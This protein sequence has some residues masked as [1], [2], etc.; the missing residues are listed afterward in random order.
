MKGQEKTIERR[1]RA[2]GLILIVVIVVPLCLLPGGRPAAAQLQS[3][4]WSQPINLSNSP[5][6]SSRPAI[7][8]DGY[9]YVHV[10]WGE[11]VGGE[12][13]LDEP[14]ALIHNG[15]T[16]YYTQWDGVSWTQ[17]IDILF[18]PDD[19]VADYI[20][21]TV[22]AE[23][24]LHVVWTGQSN[25]YYSTAPAWQADS[26]HGWSDP[27]VVATDSARS[28]WESD[29]V[30]DA[31]GNIHIVY[32]TRGDEPGVYHIQSQDGGMT[33]GP[34][35]KLS[36]PLDRLEVSFSN[37]RANADDAGRVHVVWQTNQAE[38]YGQGVYYARSIDGGNN[39]MAPVRM[40]YRDEGEYGVSFPYLTSI[41]ESELHLI[42]I[43]GPWHIG[44]YHR[45]SR[46]G[47]ETWSE[48]S[49]IL[50]D[51]EGINGYP[52]LLVDGAGGLHLVITMRTVT[53]I[54][55]T[56]YARWLGTDWSSP[57]LIVPDSVET[58]PGAHWTAATVRLGNEIHVVWNTNFTIRAGE[59]W[60]TR[61]LIAGVAQTSAIP[62]PVTE[63]AISTPAP[64]A[65]SATPA[66]TTVPATSTP[67]TAPTSS[68]ATAIPEGR[69]VDM[70]L[71]SLAAASPAS[72]LLAGIV[73]SLLLVAG[74]VAWVRVRSR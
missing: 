6:S 63:T 33:W 4:V 9:G 7:V 40:G 60:H 49:H 39:W 54:K 72:P 65:A 57:E 31:N 2:A 28:Q 24:R 53:Q 16:I 17:P 37:V 36:E 35:T 27:V 1:L 8:A 18:V 59:I 11:E 46:D 61:G 23:N 12:S 34:P 38:G 62:V 43:D 64:A 56:F 22:D 29:I 25:F 67:T 51:L 71:S 3:V 20:A 55:G 30:V 14:D 32:A 70:L 42:Y 73:P 68:A 26:A 13:I 21:V 74:V 52:L 66:L 10:F 47:G 50:T 15:N 58:G 48:P 5:E 19:S 41:G 69:S 44:R 45:I